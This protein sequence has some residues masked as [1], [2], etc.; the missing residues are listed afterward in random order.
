MKIPESFEKNIR[1]SKIEFEPEYG[2]Y[3]LRINGWRMGEFETKNE[4]EKALAKYRQM[5]GEWGIII[6]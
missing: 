6:V 5:F 4:T 3:I 1:I 2:K